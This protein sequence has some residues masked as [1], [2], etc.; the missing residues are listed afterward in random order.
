VLAAGEGNRLRALTTRPCGSAVPKQFCSLHG[1]QSLL[2]D[3]LDRAAA[4]T[5]EER[6]CTIVANQHRQ[7]WSDIE[8]VNRLRPGNVIVQP[9][10]CG[11]AIGVLYS[12]LHIL[13][14]D[15]D[16]LVILLP[17]DHFVRE[18]DTLRQSL[19]SAIELTQG[20]ASC[21]VLLG[22]E[23]E[24]TDTE[25]GY[26]LPEAASAPG[27]STVARFVEK[28]EQDEALELI[29]A[30]G[31][32]NSFIIAASGRSIVELFL[33]RYAALVAE[34]QM[35]LSRGFA[36]GSPTAVWPAIVDMYERLPDLDF[37]RDLLQGR[38]ERLRVLRVPACGW[39]DLGTPRRV[40]DTLQ[41]L[42]SSDHRPRESSRAPY[43]NLA[44]E[45]AARKRSVGAGA[46]A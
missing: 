16:A 46:P 36:A 9:R 4:L 40:A 5:D 25:L 22:V 23:P 41:R 11:T 20:D 14:A 39:S 29:Q 19:V 43:V 1:G 44:A 27:A 33:P 7:W 38:E 45:Y 13:A 8:R 26:I 24:E 15:P 2:E 17:A 42:Q 12:L 3:A 35:I 37:S 10:N 28:P 31:L 32:W 30:G 34:M 6:I 21:S 18:E